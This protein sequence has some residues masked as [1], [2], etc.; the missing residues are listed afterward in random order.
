MA[1]KIKHD[2]S[3]PSPIGLYYNAHFKK[4]TIE[5]KG[6]ILDECYKRAL[7]KFQL[8]WASSSISVYKICHYF[9]SKFGLKESDIKTIDALAIESYFD[10]YSNPKYN[11]IQLDKMTKDGVLKDIENKWVVIPNMSAKW[12]PRLAY[13]FYNELRRLGAI[14]FIFHSDGDASL[15]KVLV[16]KTLI[17]VTQFPEELYKESK[18]LEDDGY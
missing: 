7:R 1:E 6:H 9:S 3:N 5:E 18:E 10:I 16:E 15:G 12:T 11:Q 17:R 13:L 4:K 2:N 14:G 8:I